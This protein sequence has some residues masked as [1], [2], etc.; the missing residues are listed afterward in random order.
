MLA[1]KDC[2][3][4]DNTV[5]ATHLKYR[6]KPITTT[7][8]S[9][10]KETILMETPFNPFKHSTLLGRVTSFAASAVNREFQKSFPFF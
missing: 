7:E 3:C 1:I 4:L 5:F 9:K 2:Q 6:Y 8:C 10:P